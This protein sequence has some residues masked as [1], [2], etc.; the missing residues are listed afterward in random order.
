MFLLFSVHEETQEIPTNTQEQQQTFI[1]VLE[2][3]RVHFVGF[4]NSIYFLVKL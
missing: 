1:K 4:K 2:S 3:T